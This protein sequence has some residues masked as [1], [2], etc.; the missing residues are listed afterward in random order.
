VRCQRAENFGSQTAMTFDRKNKKESNVL[1]ARNKILLAMVSA[2]RK[3]GSR[4]GLASPLRSSHEV[5]G[6]RKVC[7]AASQPSSPRPA[8]RGRCALCCA[9][10]SLFALNMIIS[11]ASNHSRPCFNLSF[12][13]SLLSLC[14]FSGNQWVRSHPDLSTTPCDH[15]L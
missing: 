6:T 15:G 12:N 5:I 8:D 4:N 14:N 3:G 13:R 11:T 1:T 10:I 2:V 7:S 9:L